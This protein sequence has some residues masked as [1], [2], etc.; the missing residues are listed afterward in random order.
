MNF[1][2]LSGSRTLAA[3][4][5]V[6]SQLPPQRS[7]APLPEPEDLPVVVAVR[8]SL[9]FPVLLSAVPLYAVD[10]IAENMRLTNGPSG[11]GFPMAGSAAIFLFTFLTLRCRDGQRLESTWPTNI[12]ITIR[13]FTFPGKRP[14]ALS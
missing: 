7:S 14:Q 9:S 10:Y 12:R 4:V 8:M 6:Q 13:V 3:P 5:P 1:R 11:A 2:R